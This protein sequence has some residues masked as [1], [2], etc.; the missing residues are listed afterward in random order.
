MLSKLPIRAALDWE[1]CRDQF[2]LNLPHI[3][4]LVALSKHARR[5]FL[6]VLEP[7]V[8]VVVVSG[9]VTRQT[10]C[11]ELGIVKEYP[12]HPSIRPQQL[13]K[14]A[15]E[16]LAILR[17]LKIEHKILTVF[18]KRPHVSLDAKPVL[19]VRREFSTTFMRKLAD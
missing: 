9:S 2:C 18:A 4:A 1:P 10:F 3:F 11:H 19:V 6:L 14:L 8:Q 5:R 17:A 7:K 16:I 13:N 12:V 15:R